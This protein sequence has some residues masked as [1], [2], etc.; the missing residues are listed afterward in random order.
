MG[1]RIEQRLVFVLAVQLNQPIGELFERA[2]RD[3]RAVDE[4]ATAPLRRDLS[5]DE[6]LFPTTL[7]DRLDRRRVLTGPHEIARR[8]SAEEQ[9]DGLHKNRF[10]GSRLSGQDIQPG[11]EFH[12]DR[13]DHGEAFDG[14]EAKHGVK[15]SLLPDMSFLGRA[16]LPGPVTQP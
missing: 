11:V 1:C 12:F 2:S 16:A 10:S 7:E 5:P 3:E 14:E 15:R 13:I 4:G 6:Q 8:P 9:P